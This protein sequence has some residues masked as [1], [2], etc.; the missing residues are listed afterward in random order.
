MTTTLRAQ[1]S[2]QKFTVVQQI[3]TLYYI[4]ST[5]TLP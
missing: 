5:V 1:I 2:K 4:V 3:V